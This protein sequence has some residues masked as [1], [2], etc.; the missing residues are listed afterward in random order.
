[1]LISRPNTVSGATKVLYQQYRALYY[2]SD[3]LD[4][5]YPW[6]CIL[7]RCDASIF[8]I[9]EQ[10][11]FTS[12]SVSL[13][14]IMILG[15]ISLIRECIAHQTRNS[16]FNAHRRFFYA[17]ATAANHAKFL[18]GRATKNSIC[19]SNCRRSDWLPAP[20]PCSWFSCAARR[21]SSSRKR[22]LLQRG[23]RRQWHDGSLTSSDW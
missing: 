22:L 7:F 10:F 11:M 16:E 21:W 6:R 19:L 5:K 2:K 1:M 12:P 14:H 4:S 18:T 20:T 23:Q 8:E 13:T 9:C 15:L 17:G 3:I